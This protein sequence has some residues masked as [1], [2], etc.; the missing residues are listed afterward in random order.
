MKNL[1]EDYFKTHYRDKVVYTNAQV[2]HISN[3]RYKDI[4]L[5]EFDLEADLI[6]DERSIYDNT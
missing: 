2:Q 5:K 6:M 4:S 3:L 1:P